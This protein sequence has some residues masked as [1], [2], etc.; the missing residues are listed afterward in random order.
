MLTKV[1]ALELVSNELRR[2]SS[3]GDLFVVVEEHTIDKPFGWVFFYESKKFLETGM[4]R[5]RLVGNG[6]VIIN[7]SSGSMTFYGSGSPPE[8]I[9]G[10]YEKGLSASG[11]RPNE[12]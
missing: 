7:K 1:E 3:S 9:I 6:P 8:E 4:F 11:S 2:M 5:D 12:G 10:E